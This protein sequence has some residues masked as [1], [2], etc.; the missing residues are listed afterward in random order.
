MMDA[1]VDQFDAAEDPEV[2]DDP[3]T[4]DID[5][6]VT[7]QKKRFTTLHLQEPKAKQLERAEM[8]LNVANTTP[9]HFRRYQI[10]LVASVAKVPVEVIGELPNSQ[11]VRAWH[12]LRDL[13]DETSP[14]TGET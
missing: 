4:L 8:E 5:I 3:R 11:L 14:E 6:D 10:A 12:F 7:F 13:L 2:S 1:I 9:Y